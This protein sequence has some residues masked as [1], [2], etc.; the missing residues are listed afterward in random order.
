MDHPKTGQDAANARRAAWM[1]VLALADPAA[2]DGAFSALAGKP[3]HQTLRPAQTGMA[4]V[5]A[6]SGGTGARFNLGEMTVTRCAVTMGEGVVGV[7]YVQGRSQRHAE[8]AAVAD[9]LLQ[10]PEWHDT[11][12]AQLIQPLARQHAERIERQARVAA[13]TKVEFFTMVRGED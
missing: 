11:V 13:Q 12:Q 3:E 8:Q 1:R 4:M 2:L 5:R 10:L 7:A 6:R 9:A